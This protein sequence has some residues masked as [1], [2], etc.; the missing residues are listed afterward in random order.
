MQKM[1]LAA[2][3]GLA[4]VLPFVGGVAHGAEPVHN[5]VIVNAEEGAG[6]R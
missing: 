3:S 6:V 1:K 5:S 2:V 4:V